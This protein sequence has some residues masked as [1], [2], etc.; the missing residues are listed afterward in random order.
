MSSFTEFTNGI[1]EQALNEKMIAHKKVQKWESKG[2]LE[3]LTRQ[4]KIH[5]ARLLENEAKY[6]LEASDTGDIK[7]FQSI[8]FPLVRR[9]YGQL[10]AQEIC[11]VQPMSL[12]AGLIF[13][14]DFTFGSN[15]PGTGYQDWFGGVNRSIGG[16]PI[17]PLTGGS[18]GTGG[19]YYLNS[20]YTQVEASGAV[21]VASSASV[22]AWSEVEYDFELSA[23]VANAGLHKLTV[24]LNQ[25]TGITNIDET[26]YK[27]FAVSGTAAALGA[28]TVFYRRHN[29]YNP[30]TKILTLYYS[31]TALVGGGANSGS[32]ISASYVKK[33]AHSADTTGTVTNPPFEYAFNNGDPIPTL[34]IKIA[35][36]PVVAQDRK[37]KVVWT[38][39]LAQ[40]LNAYHSIDAEQELTQMMADQIALDIDSEILQD[41]LNKAMTGGGVKLYWD[42]RPGF[43]VVRDTGAPAP[44]P[45]FTG[46]QQEW[47]LGLLE[48]ISDASNQLHRRNL[49]SGATFLVTSPDVCTI[50]ENI[51][52]WRPIVDAGDHETLKFSMGI[53]KAGNLGNRWAVYKAPFFPRNIV[54]L[55]I[56]GENWLTT[57]YV[58]APYIPL[59]VTP[60]VHTPDNFIPG[61]GA[62]TR[63]AKQCVR[64]DFFG[65]VVVKG[66][67]IF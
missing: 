20:G 62:M 65:V 33:T 28:T 39:E 57:S 10:L 47:Y 64:A 29:Q 50:L 46:N 37:L 11:S 4:K 53:E 55:G 1:T 42:R 2:L 21:G 23:A 25:D 15:K 6:L 9:V 27:L 51:V 66:M 12:P 45:S 31:G 38:P 26:N 7:G 35:S 24:D 17:V 18:S 22:T 63:Y 41:M 14:L 44:G 48:T 58:Y 36:H 40:D 16:D 49:R 59:I 52:Q 8:A 30:A 3:G 13:W 32:V 19:H 34:D 67:E 54:L 56:K 60:V 5:M 43:F 61:K